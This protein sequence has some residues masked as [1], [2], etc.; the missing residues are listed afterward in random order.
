MA[1]KFGVRWLIDFLVVSAK[2]LSLWADIG[3][4]GSVAV[5]QD[6]FTAAVEDS[7]LLL[8]FLSRRSLTMDESAQQELAHHVAAM[9][10][11]QTQV[12]ASRKLSE[13]DRAAFWEAFHSLSQLARP[14]TIESI[15]G[16]LR[17]HHRRSREAMPSAAVSEGRTTVAALRPVATRQNCS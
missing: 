1:K 2:L 9:T 7:H 13:T 11:V 6:T 16:Y 14:V 15:R 10:R 3:L 4:M 12:A 8:A 5:A 17:S